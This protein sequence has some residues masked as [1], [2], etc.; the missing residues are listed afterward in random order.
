MVIYRSSS[1]WKTSRLEGCGYEV[2]LLTRILD[3]TLYLLGAS[4]M[5][6]WLF[7]AVWIVTM[8]GIG[9]AVNLLTGCAGD[10]KRERWQDCGG[11]HHRVCKGD[12]GC[13][14]E[15]YKICINE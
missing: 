8:V 4:A 6:G 10:G 13:E 7:A 3:N 1:G 12:L 11:I 14:Y 9:L 15:L 2:V 5:R